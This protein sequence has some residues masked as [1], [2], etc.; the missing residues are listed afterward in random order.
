MSPAQQHQQ[1]Q[2]H[3]AA[4]GC[5]PLHPFRFLLIRMHIGFPLFST[6]FRFPSQE[7]NPACLPLPHFDYSTH[8]TS[9]GPDEL[10]LARGVEEVVGVGLGGEGA[11]VGLLDEVLVP[12]LLGEGD[13]VLLGLELQLR[14]L[15]GVPRRLPPHQRV[16]PPVAL[17]QH[18]PV[19]PPVVRPPRPRLR[20]GLGGLV[21]PVFGG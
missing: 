8:S 12:L 20:R 17:A 11:L 1:Q 16:L 10:E 14:P 15:H 5:R 3:P 4:Q 13:G 21:D 2:Q 9:L 19:H 6:P 7:P 18:V